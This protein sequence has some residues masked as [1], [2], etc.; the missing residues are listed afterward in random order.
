MLDVSKWTEPA[1]LPRKP[2]DFQNIT[3]LLTSYTLLY[4]VTSTQAGSW[5]S[6]IEDMAGV[7]V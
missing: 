1:L 3:P 6:G 5:R 4:K 7:F 2:L